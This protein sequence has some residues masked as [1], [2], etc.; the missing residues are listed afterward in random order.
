MLR[1]VPGNV[2]A[3][4]N[5]PTTTTTATTSTHRIKSGAHEMFSNANYSFKVHDT[6]S[7]EFPISRDFLNLQIREFRKYPE[8]SRDC[9]PCLLILNRFPNVFPIS[10][11]RTREYWVVES[12]G[13]ATTHHQKK[14]NN[15]RK[16]NTACYRM[17]ITL[18]VR[19]DNIMSALYTNTLHIS[20]Q[21]CLYSIHLHTT[22]HTTYSH[23]IIK[24]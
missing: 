11:V 7:V 18:C 19:V 17:H 23:N 13:T 9:I 4:V 5:R 24:Y 1:L 12:F 16:R 15:A 20:A 21:T 6:R 22:Q 14:K 3:P 10:N 8:I 2:V